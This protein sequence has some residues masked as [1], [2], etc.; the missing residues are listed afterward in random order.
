MLRKLIK[1]L[2]LVVFI[3]ASCHLG[4]QLYDD[5]L[6]YSEMQSLSQESGWTVT[7][8]TFGPPQHLRARFLIEFFL[9]VAL[10]GS[11]L[12]RL[13][14]TFLSIIGLSGAVISYIFW[15]QYIFRLMRNAET[16]ADSIPNF[17]YLAG[18]T[19]VD[20][21]LAGGIAM[22]VVVNV[23]G[24]AASSLRLD[25]EINNHDSSN[26]PSQT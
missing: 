9:I 12:K 3:T 20:V 4:V 16:T 24:A 19:F 13:S 7:V 14:N 1:E 25:L 18:G 6:R 5:H 10:I 15:W 8:C 23:I 22:L 17:A 11:R 26:G 21:A 2:T